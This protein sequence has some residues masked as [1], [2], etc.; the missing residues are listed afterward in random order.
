MPAIPAFVTD[1]L[2]QLGV[3]LDPS[4]LDT[5]ARYLDR[6]LD[7]TQRIN[8]TAVREPDA[9][10]RRLIIDSL[11]LVPGF[12]PVA[13]DATIIDIGTGGGL[14]GIPLAIA[15]PDLR[16]TLLEATG[17]KVR[18]LNE[19]IEALGLTNTRAIQQRAELLGQDP[20]HRQQYDIAVS[21]AVGPMTEVLEYSLPLVK[22]GGRVLAMKGPKLEQELAAAGDALGI[23]GAGDMEVFEAYPPNFKQ[24]LV[25]A[26]IIKDRATP[27]MYPRR[28]GVPKH[29][30]L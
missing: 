24:D 20:A 30:P 2:S 7:T 16:V 29:E 4:Q 21:R 27:G 12:E 10:W 19:C 11:S 6:L 9:A 28:P 18:F 8:L 23:L 1:E 17:K 26:S 14:P 3:T 22:V 5:L 15:R 25:I 13:E